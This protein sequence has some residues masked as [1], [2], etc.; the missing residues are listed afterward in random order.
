MDARVDDCSPPNFSSDRKV[1][2][3]RASA[4]WETPAGRRPRG[5]P[6]R[7]GARAAVGEHE[8]SV[9]PR[10]APQSAMAIGAGTCAR[11]AL[12]R[13]GRWTRCPGMRPAR[14]AGGAGALGTGRRKRSREGAGGGAG[15]EKEVGEAAGEGRGRGEEGGGGRGRRFGPCLASGAPGA[16]PPPCVRFPARA[17]A[18]RRPPPRPAGPAAAC[19]S[20]RRDCAVAD[21]E[22]FFSP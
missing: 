10:Q 8:E 20:R 12:P 14:A 2:E 3:I 18:P 13:K 9:G 22:A 17:L 6:I 1:P 7:A 11:V 5:S 4:S 21:R 19:R 15:R 16:R